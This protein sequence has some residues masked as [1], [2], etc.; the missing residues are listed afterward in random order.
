MKLYPFSVQKHAHDVEF[1]YNR[2]KN[3][4]YDVESGSVSMSTA[5]YNR[6]HDFLDNRLL[7][8]YTAMFDSHDGRV[9]YLSGEQIGLAKEIVLWASEQR[10]QTLIKNKKYRYLKYC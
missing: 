4:L 7:P 6:L 8:L 5:E 1:F 3:T 9:T 2:I 10:S